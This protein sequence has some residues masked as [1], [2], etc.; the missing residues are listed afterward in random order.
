M[1]PDVLRSV[2]REILIGSPS[3]TYWSRF[4]RNAVRGMLE[5]AVPP[6]MPSHIGGCVVADR[7]GGRAPQVTGVVVAQIKHLAR[8]IADGIVGPW[9]ELV[10][11]AVDRP[12]VAAA[13]GRHL[14]AEFRIG[15]DI[16]PGCR[17]CLTRPEDRHV[18]P[19]RHWRSHRAR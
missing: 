18:F 4:D 19:V 13:F 5:L 17:R 9:S 1:R 12:G 16:D 2:R 11:A 14:K 7:R 10:L 6:A 15:D 8:A 3:G